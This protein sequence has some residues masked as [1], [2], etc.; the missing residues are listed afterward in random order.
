MDNSATPLALAPSA[1][2]TLIPSSFARPSGILSVPVPFLLITRSSVAAR[3]T[4]S[5]IGS[6]P[7][8]HPTQP[9]T[10]ARSCSSVGT[11]PAFAK[12]SSKPAASSRPSTGSFLSVKDRGVMR[13]RWLIRTAAQSRK[14][15]DR[16]LTF[17]SPGADDIVDCS[18]NAIHPLSHRQST[19]SCLRTGQ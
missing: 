19:I 17:R 6:T 16:Y 18:L 14:E 15:E 13:T 11:W 7:A 4:R 5:E 1:F 2:W 3:K 8:I 9:G 12:T 10:S